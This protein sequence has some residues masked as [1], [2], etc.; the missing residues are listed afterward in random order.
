MRLMRGMT[1]RRT[2][3]LAAAVL[4]AGLAACASRPEQPRAPAPETPDR[5]ERPVEPEPAAP[6]RVGV[7]LPQEGTPTLRQY[8]EQVRTG[9]DI[10]FGNLQ[11]DVEVVIVDDG[12]DPTRAAEHTR[13][14]EAR[15]VVAIVGP[16]LGEAVDAAAAARTDPDLALISPTASERPA[17]RNAYTLNANDAR[18]GTALA[19]WALANGLRDV[20]LL[21]PAGADFRDQA[22]AFRTAIQQGGGRVVSDVAWQ[23]GTTTFAEPLE[24][25]RDSRALAMFVGA[26]ERDIRQ[27]APQLAYYG[28]GDVQIL[29]TE[30]WADEAVLAR[31]EPAIVEGVVAAVPF[32][33]TSPA[34]A[35][36]EFVG[37]Y[38]AAQRRSL[39]NPY[40]ALGWDAARLILEAIGD[41]G[42][43]SRADVARRLAD[44]D[45]FRGATGVLSLEDG[46]VTRRP[47]LVRIRNGR[48]E[49][50]P[51][52]RR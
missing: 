27:L 36:D 52:P 34:V 10:A 41:D 20:A 8:G 44:T 12:G 28:V 24:R 4:A 45:A 23:P 50:I 38:E 3:R 2:R 17:G 21:Y 25:I 13:Q 42:R 49:P 5:P 26:G 35:W 31:M 9:L 11:R 51:D 18:G 43:P 1:L 19:E 7:I 33:A 16:L 37:L 47:F 22:A 14:L 40:P 29:G 46:A 32:L 15:G 6:I 30:A 39:D 48:A